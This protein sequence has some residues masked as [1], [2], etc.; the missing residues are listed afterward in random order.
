MLGVKIQ[1]HTPMYTYWSAQ[2][3]H[4][5][6]TQTCAIQGRFLFRPHSLYYEKKF[7]LFAK[8]STPLQNTLDLQNTFSK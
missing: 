1:T 3:Q 7:N 8:G 4:C 2:P 5:V 6:H